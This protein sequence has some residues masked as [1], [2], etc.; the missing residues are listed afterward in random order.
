MKRTLVS[1][2]FQRVSRKSK[3]F[4]FWLVSQEKS[5]SFQNLKRGSFPEGDF[6]W[7]WWDLGT[8]GEWWVL[9]DP[10]RCRLSADCHRSTFVEF[11]PARDSHW[12]YYF[13][14]GIRQNKWFRYLE[15]NAQCWAPKLSLK[16]LELAVFRSQLAVTCEAMFLNEIME[17]GGQWKEHHIWWTFRMIPGLLWLLVNVGAAGD[18]GWL[19]FLNVSVHRSTGPKRALCACGV[20]TSTETQPAL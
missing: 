4:G 18:S 3:Y 20:F 11:V 1:E 19:M 16:I 6:S 14:A 15:K 8:T 2:P 17:H 7:I 10:E 12:S 9:S 13:R 5:P